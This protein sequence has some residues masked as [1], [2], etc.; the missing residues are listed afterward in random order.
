MNDAQQTLINCF[1]F[2]K[3]SITEYCTSKASSFI[4]LSTAAPGSISPYL[5]LKQ[6]YIHHP[7]NYNEFISKSYLSVK[8]LALS[9]LMAVNSGPSILKGNLYSERLGGI[10]LDM[11]ENGCFVFAA[12][13][14]YSCLV[15]NQQHFTFNPDT[16]QTQ[17]AASWIVSRLLT[18]AVKSGLGMCTTIHSK[19]ISLVGLLKDFK[20][21][22]TIIRL[23]LRLLLNKF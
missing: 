5:L 12:Q 20:K 13:H 8:Q 9:E 1:S 10:S 3:N 2:L 4:S 18:T 15:Q 17:I 19:S 22:H 6:Y 23:F 21:S 16:L 11:F 14:H 7:Q